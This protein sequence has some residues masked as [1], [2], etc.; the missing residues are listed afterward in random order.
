M[1]DPK[2]EVTE[3]KKGK[4]ITNIFTDRNHRLI[5][6]TGK[7]KVISYA[8]DNNQSLRNDN[9]VNDDLANNKKGIYGNR[10]EYT[11]NNLNELIEEKV[12]SHEYDSS[13]LKD[14]DLSLT[15]ENTFDQSGE[16]IVKEKT[17]DT[18]IDFAS[19]GSKHYLLENTIFP[20][21][22]KSPAP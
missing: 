2:N 6:I 7:Y 12:V 19:D 13:I 11:H 22:T 15:K 5:G 9:L 16:F 3:V 21:G 17:N 4:T 1:Y 18:E 10:T 20:D 8:Y 14:R